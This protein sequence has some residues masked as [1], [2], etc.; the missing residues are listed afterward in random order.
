MDL[1]INFRSLIISKV[2]N[3]VK[4]YSK[5]VSTKDVREEGKGEGDSEI[6]DTILQGMGRGVN[7]LQEVNMDK[8]SS[9]Y[10]YVMHLIW[11]CQDYDHANTSKASL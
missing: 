5:G 4:D 8:I 9:K 1:D 2:E 3:L 7:Q 10:T 11:L 6:M